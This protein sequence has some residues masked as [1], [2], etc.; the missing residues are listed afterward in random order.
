MLALEI[1]GIVLSIPEHPYE[2]VRKNKPTVQ[3]EARASD[4]ALNA[5]FV[6]VLLRLCGA[7][8]RLCK[9]WQ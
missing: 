8:G 4:L 9:K 7:S 2:K 3:T 1:P 5:A 6:V